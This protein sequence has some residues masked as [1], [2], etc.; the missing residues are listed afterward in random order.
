[1]KLRCLLASAMLCQAATAVAPPASA[2]SR[3]P[4][5]APAAPPAVAIPAPVNVISV[6]SM[7][8]AFTAPQNCRPQP[9]AAMPPQTHGGAALA[10]HVATADQRPHA[11]QSRHARTIFGN[12]G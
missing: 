8:I 12:T 2:L 4:P 9:D 7:G 11:G 6:Q 10:G 1:M 5:P 3:T